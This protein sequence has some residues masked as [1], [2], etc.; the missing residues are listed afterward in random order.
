MKLK[1]CSILIILLSVKSFA[2][3]K[4]EQIEK[5]DSVAIVE[6][7]AVEMKAMQKKA[8]STRIMK[9]IEG[10]TILAGKK[11]E[12][13]LL[14]QKIA[15]LST[16]NARQIYNQIV[17]LNIYDYNDGGLQ[18]G[19]GGRGLNP[20][21]TANFNTRQNGY[22]ISADVLGYPES[23]Y[24][25]PAEALGE[26]QIIRG[27]ASLQYGTQFGGL[28]NFV[29]KEPP[30]HKKIE[31][32][33]RQTIGSYN[34]FTSFNSLG[35]TVDKFSYYT[36][37]N[38]KKGDGFRPNTNFNAHNAFA[39]FQYRLSNATTLR[40]EYT[41]FGYLAQQPGG[42]TDKMFYE[43]PKYSNRA[44]N[45]FSVDWN[46]WN[47]NFKHQFNKRTN[48]EI[49][50]F[51]LKAY[52]KTVGFRVQR[53]GS[54]D[55]TSVARDLIVGEFKNWGSEVKL[56]HRYNF[57]GKENAFLLGGKYY[58]SRNTSEQGPGTIAADADFNFDYKTSP[59]YPYQSAFEYPN[60][61]LSVFGE[62]IFRITPEI[63]ITPGF[64]YEYIDTRAQGNYHHFV[65]DNAGNVIIDKIN[66]ED[67]QYQRKFLLL[68]VG[69]S[70][71]PKDWAEVYANLS[72]N[73]R[74]VTF[75]DIHTTNP[76]FLVDENIR[77]ES[78]YTADIGVRGNVNRLVFYDSNLYMLMYK[79]KIGNYIRK[80]D[81][82]TIRAN[83]GDALT[84]GVECFIEADGNKI[85]GINSRYLLLSA[86]VNSSFSNSKYLSSEIVR[87]KGKRVQF[88]PDVNLKTGVNIGYRNLIGSLQY[89]FVSEQFTDDANS[90]QNNL[91]DTYGTRG[92]IPAYQVVDLS[93]SYTYKK[94]KLETG[95]NNL[96]NN[97]YFVRR[98]TGYPGPGII[99]SD[100]RTFY[101]TFGFKL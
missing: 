1:V 47:V 3:E 72:Q 75:S 46:L 32:N 29:F 59:E 44:R 87:V 41:Y 88:N 77:D 80:V 63:S 50:T 11:T 85:L 12:V 61:N 25:P 16:N 93:L 51:A 52:R 69:I 65:K 20:N 27:A 21:R 38:F 64:R 71:K 82:K 31:L 99:P 5:K 45:W 36:F 78:G 49:N 97:S 39:H 33:S 53:V 62:N 18:L 60:L 48:I 100:P 67:K 43:N 68:G 7:S 42:L 101:L 56:L 86:F 94:Y 34:L 37:Y 92:A 55:D 74:S 10:T 6:L 14:S 35:G 66:P 15:N 40:L 81:A 89:T 70:Y 8:L 2:Q 79:N 73:Y 83:V 57:Q 30:S 28:I 23:Y 95:I 9:D 91:E 24:T 17:G 13:V 22:D 90:P 54:P 96:L 84:Y 76:S 26:I 98:A 4:K 19:I 58:Q